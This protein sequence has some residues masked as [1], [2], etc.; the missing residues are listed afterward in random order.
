M[1]CGVVVS[2]GIAVVAAVVLKV[3]TVV[4]SEKY[5]TN[6]GGEQG[7]S[8]ASHEKISLFRKCRSH[9]DDC[10]IPTQCFSQ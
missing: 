7:E 6:N 1:G 5:K 4:P 9:L 2:V 10:R 3:V 8:K